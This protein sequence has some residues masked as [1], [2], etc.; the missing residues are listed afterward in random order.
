MKISPLINFLNENNIAWCPIKTI[1]DENGIK[2]M[3]DEEWINKPSVLTWWDYHKDKINKRQDLLLFSDFDIYNTINIDTRKVL[4]FDIDIKDDNEFEK[5]SI[6]EKQLYEKL[7]TTLPNYK[8]MTKKY[9]RHIFI[10]DITDNKLSQTKINYFR[11]YLENKTKVSDYDKYKKNIEENATEQKT[12][13]YVKDHCGWIEILKGC[14]SWANP[15]TIFVDNKIDNKKGFNILT[16]ILQD[17]Y[18]K[19]EVKQTKKEKRRTSTKIKVNKELQDKI[20]KLSPEEK[21]EN[22]FLQIKEHISNINFKYIEDHNN[23]YKLLGSVVSLKNDD[24][25]LHFKNIISQSEK[26]KGNFDTW[27]NKFVEQLKN[28]KFYKGIIYQNSKVSNITKFFEINNKYN[29][30]IGQNTTPKGLADMFFDI[31]KD[32]IVVSKT[33]NQDKSVIYNYNEFECIWFNQNIEFENIKFNITNEILALS[34]LKLTYYNEKLNDAQEKKDEELC[35]KYDKEITKYGILEKQIQAPALIEKIYTMLKMRLVAKHNSR[36]EFDTLKYHIPFNNKIKLNVLTGEVTNIFRDDFIETMLSYEYYEPEQKDYEQF[37]TAFEGCFMD[38]EYND[39]L[40]RLEHKAIMNDVIYILATGLIGKQ[41]QNVFIFNGAGGNGKSIFMNI[42]EKVIDKFIYKAQG[43]QLE[44]DI[45]INKPAPEWANLKQK[46]SYIFEEIKE[47]GSISINTCKIISGSPNLQARFLHQNPEKIQLEGTTILICNTTPQLRGVINDAI[48]RRFIDIL[49]RYNFKVP[50]TDQ[51]KQHLG[52]KNEKGEVI[53]YKSQNGDFKLADTSY[54]DSDFL[55]RMK[56]PMLKYL[57]E[58]IKDYPVKISKN[59]ISFLKEDYEFSKT[60]QLRT[61]AYLS[62]Q[63]QFGSFM[64]D[65][66]IQTGDTSDRIQ[67]SSGDSLYKKYIELEQE[68]GTPNKE[69]MKLCKFKQQL[70]NTS[71]YKNNIGKTSGD[72]MTR[73]EGKKH[74]NQGQYIYGFYW[75]NIYDTELEKYNKAN[76]IQ[77]ETDSE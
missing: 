43:E 27:F 17:K 57:L 21:Q 15:D 63:N 37:V 51:A 25:L 44:N 65:I 13:N 16:E 40:L 58:W 19:A 26:C 39:D 59:N 5:L 35:D 74:F 32:N 12:F 76:N 20:K 36:V 56:L 30:S 54:E 4:Q 49:W 3:Q 38:E 66:L 41:V 18:F 11:D 28:K 67:I 8:S 72:Y 71:P 75:R 46:R 52:I 61:K 53:S 29:P 31:N 62:A 77:I 64:E 68:L 1:I 50:G 42:Y 73:F 33:S 7:I 23:L 6:R 69:C 47:G 45:N 22:N 48:T 10:C 60:T 55:D 24:V 34:K 9:G 70:Q 2:Q 14:N